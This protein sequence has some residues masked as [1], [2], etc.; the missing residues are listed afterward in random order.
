VKIVHQNPKTGEIK[1]IA[2][3]L[4]DIWHL[5]NIIQPGDHVRAVTFRT[6]EDPSSDRIRATKTEKK[7]MTLT[8]TVDKVEFHE[9]S[10]RLR[11]HGVIT[12][13]PQDLGQ[14]HTFN[15]DTEILEPITLIKETWR[16]HDIERLQE[17]VN[18][19]TEP[20]LLFVSLDEDTATIA[21][22]RQS[23]IQLIAEIDAHRS[24][25]MYESKETTS[26]YYGD[27]LG[28]I[29]TT[30]TPGTPL[31]I[32]GPGFAREHLIAYGK[33]KE[34]S[35]FDSFVTYPTGHASM[36]GINEAIKS[37]IVD[38][39][40][41]DNRVS[42]ETQAVEHLLEEVRKD[43]LAT[44][45]PKEV[46]DALQR[47]AVDTLLIS[48]QCIRSRQG[49]R[50]LDLARKTTSRFLIINSLHEAGKKFEGLG[51]IAAIL[52]YKY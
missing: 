25:K 3:N 50:Y 4:D 44:Y 21:V 28:I 1:L 8:L 46:E 49:E 2:E 27:I 47:G 22:L 10:N 33:S 20:V 17:A 38:K 13:G 11:I 34:P 36:N 37:G 6:A 32:I 5:H 40:T 19:R 24:G 7:R 26:E 29:K 23:G 48:D 18:Q 51:G 12:E 39:L 43:G 16:P 35:L 14:H 41:K 30:K 9:F 31:V 42:K 45:G 15:V 52:R